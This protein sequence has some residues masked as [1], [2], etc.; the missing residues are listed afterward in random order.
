VKTRHYSV[1][2][3]EL[4]SAILKNRK[5][6][7]QNPD[8]QTGKLCLY[9]GMTGLEP[10]KRYENHKKGYKSSAKVKKF[11]KCLRPDLFPPGNPMTYSDAT[12]KETAW[13]DQLRSRGYAVWQ[14]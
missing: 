3:V 11:G 6:Q 4:D 9:V 5:F 10:A 8:R 14:H 13:A 12:A 7:E 2:V 1:Y